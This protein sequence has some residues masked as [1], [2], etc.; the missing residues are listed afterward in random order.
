MLLYYAINTLKGI[1]MMCTLAISSERTI[2]HRTAGDILACFD[3]CVARD[4][5]STQQTE[6]TRQNKPQ[7][8]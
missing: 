1:P 5:M 7:Y 2:K 3:V 4:S 8:F 6:F